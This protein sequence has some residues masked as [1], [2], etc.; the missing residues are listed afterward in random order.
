M[1]SHI[2]AKFV[3][4]TFLEP[5]RSTTGGRSLIVVP[6]DVP[7][8]GFRSS[9]SLCTRPSRSSYVYNVP[10]C[11]SW[12]SIPDDVLVMRLRPRFFFTRGFSCYVDFGAYVRYNTVRISMGKQ[13]S[14]IML[15]GSTPVD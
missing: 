9:M 13:V 7:K 1:Y 10:G 15:V 5:N 4:M 3:N 8:E 2:S 12:V 6:L 14:I 11:H